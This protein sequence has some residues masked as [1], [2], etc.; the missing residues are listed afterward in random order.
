VFFSDK[1]KRYIHPTEGFLLDRYPR[2][3]ALPAAESAVLE[4]QCHSALARYVGAGR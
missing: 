3:Q 4:A 1:V 2:V